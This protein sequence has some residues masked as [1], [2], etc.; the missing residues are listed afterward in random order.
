MIPVDVPAS[1]SERLN[2]GSVSKR[3]YPWDE[4]VIDWSVPIDDE[5]DYMP[6]GFSFLDGTPLRE[7]LTER[8]RSF[9]TR[10][11]F[12]R[13]MRNQSQGEHIL[14]QALLGVLYHVDPYD[15]AWRYL[16][17]EVAEE[18]QHMSMFNDW[19]RRNADIRTHGLGQDQFGTGVS[20]LTPVLA[21]RFPALL[22]MMTYLFEVFGDQMARAAASDANARLHPIVRQLMQAHVIEEARHVTFA[23]EWL[24]RLHA[25]MSR[26]G[27][28]ALAVTAEQILATVLRLKFPFVPLLWSGQI[29]PWVSR[30][31][32]RRAMRSEHRRALIQA[33]VGSAAVVLLELGVVRP[34]TLDRWDATGLLPRHRVSRR[35]LFEPRAL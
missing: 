6:S 7:K 30:R 16:L 33:Q 21:T 34:R 20:V 24:S 4:D 27:Q 8:Q 5:H 23:R 18:C 19:V 2:R 26:P 25:R 29:A 22:W 12:T 35:P 28:L 15:P 9:V 31:D 3:C 1:L 11:E 17:H 32:F 14:N 10:W 13:L